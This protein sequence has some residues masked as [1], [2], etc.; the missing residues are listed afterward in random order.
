MEFFY[1]GSPRS[2]AHRAGHKSDEY[3]EDHACEDELPCSTAWK[4]RRN[5]LWTGLLREWSQSKYSC[6]QKVVNSW[7]VLKAFPELWLLSKINMR[8][9][10]PDKE[11]IQVLIHPF[12]SETIS[13]WYSIT[14]VSVYPAGNSRARD[15]CSEQIGVYLASVSHLELL[16]LA[17]CAEQW[18]EIICHI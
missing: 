2:R 10:R 18:S 6:S 15:L 8:F 9:S 16:I 17:K 4:A 11:Y 7:K 3:P 14:I 5:E 1:L 13:L 12:E